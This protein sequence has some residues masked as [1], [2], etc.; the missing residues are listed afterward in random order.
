M[1]LQSR[2]NEKREEDDFVR[3]E[4][5]GEITG[6]DVVEGDTG[7]REGVLDRGGDAIGITE[8]GD[9]EWSAISDLSESGGDVLSNSV[10]IAAFG[11]GAV[12]D[13]PP[14]R[15][16]GLDML[17]LGRLCHPSTHNRHRKD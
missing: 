10:G 15:C 14:D 12:L 13:V 1:G 9:G 8:G 11:D 5:K 3:L 2:Y 6:G 16:L 4:K 17:P 7:G